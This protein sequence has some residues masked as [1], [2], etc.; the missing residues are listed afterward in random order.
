MVALS[1]AEQVNP[2]V[3]RYLNR[4]SDLMFVLSRA[5]NGAAGEVL[6]QPGANRG[7]FG[8]TNQ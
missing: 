4:L 1:H 3:I 5:L 2:A 7:G 6:W 8:S